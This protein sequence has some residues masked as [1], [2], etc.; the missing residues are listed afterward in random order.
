MVL[1]FLTTSEIK[2]LESRKVMSWLANY[3]GRSPKLILV[4]LS[5]YKYKLMS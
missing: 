2:F 5:H 1:K 4:F 3:L